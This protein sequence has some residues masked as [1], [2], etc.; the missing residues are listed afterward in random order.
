M[1]KRGSIAV[2]LVCEVGAM[3]VWFASAVVAALLPQGGA[4]SGMAAWLTAAVQ[5]GRMF[6]MEL[7]ERRDSHRTGGARGST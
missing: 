7:V 3:A 1:D 2:L 4:A 5:A 6:W